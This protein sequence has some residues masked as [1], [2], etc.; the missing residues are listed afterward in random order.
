MKLLVFEYS[1]ICLNETLLSEGFNMLKSVLDDLDNNPFFDIYYLI[2]RS[3]ESLDYENLKS[4]YLDD[5]LFDGTIDFL[6]Y[7]KRIGGKA[8][9]LT[10][11]SSKSVKKYI[12]KLILKLITQ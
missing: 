10:N 3:I 5:D 12:E 8:M 4:I 6:E 1:S 9:Y 7:V 2:N 11:N